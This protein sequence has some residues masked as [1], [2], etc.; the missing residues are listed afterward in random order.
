MNSKPTYKEL[1]EE[2]A[3][4]KISN[5]L[6]KKSPIV[7]FLW[8]N[9]ETWPVEYVSENVKNVFG[10][11]AE[12]FITGKIVYSEIIY[13]EDLQRVENEVNSQSKT[14]FY[15]I[16][17]EPYRIVS[18]A[19]KINWLN[20]ITLIRRNENNEITHFEGIIIDI[21]KQKETEKELIE[22]KLRWKFAVEGNA[23]G[24]WDWNLITNEVF[25]STQWK[26]ML[27]FSENEIQGSL[28]EWGNRVHP[29]DK[30]K[31]YQDINKHIN[32]ET[33][34]YENEHRVLCKDNT[35]KWILDRGKIV[36]YTSDNKPE[37]MIGTHSDITDRKKAEQALKQS[38]ENLKRAQQ[39]AK[40]GHWELDI[41]NNKLFWTDE[42]FRIFDLKPQEFGATYEAFLNNI[43]PDDKEKVDL[44]YANSLKDKIP[45]E[46]EHRLLLR[47]GK[48]KYVV[49]RCNTE[50]NS[51]G[52]PIF[53]IGTILDITERKKSEETLS[54]FKKIRESTSGHMSFIDTNFVYRE[55]NN[56]YIKAHKKKREE[57][58]G[59]TIAE[60]LGKEIFEN[61]IKKEIDACL[62]GEIVKYENW[63]DFAGIGKRYMQVSYYPFY[64]EE[65][66]ISG[67]IVDSYDITDR[68][69]A[70]T[71][72]ANK[73]MLLDN[74]TNRA[75]NV[76]IITTDLDLKIT[77]YN[78]FAE[79]FFG[80]S[81]EQVIGKTVHEMHFME[82]IEPERL[83][84]AFKIVNKTGE[85]NYI[86]NQQ[87]P[88]GKRV[89]S[90]R[91]TK[92]LNPDGELT[93][94]SLFTHD[95]TKQVLA[96]EKLLQR[97][98]YLVALNKTTKILSAGDP[99]TQIQKFIETIGE[100]AHASRTY[101][102]KNHT[103]E[104]NEL[105]LSQI[106]EYVAEGIKPEIDNP[107]LQNL[108]YN[109]WLPR[110]HKTL[111]KGEIV[112]GKVAKFAESEREILE[113]QNI[114]AILVI[115]IIIEKEFWGF[116][117]FDNC[118]ND[119]EL[120][121]AEI[122][123]LKAS[124]EK[125]STKIKERRKQ[126]LLENE[127]KRFH[128]TMNSIDAPVYV[129]DMQTHELLFQNKNTKKLFGNKLGQKCY[130]ALQGLDKP[131]DFCTN[132]K[133][134]DK[135]G[136]PNK[137]Y[138]WE[139]QNTITEQWYQCRDQAIQWTDGRLVRL[140]IATDITERKKIED[141]LKESEEK[142]LTVANFAYDWEYWISPQNEFIYISPSCKRITGYSQDEFKQN[143]E[144]ISSIVHPDDVDNWENH[145]HNDFDKNEIG[146]IEFRIITKSGKQRWI[147]H[148]CQ[149]VFD[150]NGVNI[151]IRG[152]NRDITDKK[153]T[154]QAL[155]VSE[156]RLSK[157]LI[158][159][160]DGMWDWDLITNKVYFD[161]RYYE[162]AGYAVDEFPHEF[163]EFQKRIHSD[164]V[165]NVMLQ[166]QQHLKGEIPRFNV[167]FR[168][169]KKSGDW[170]WI[171]GRGQIVERDKNNKPL[172]F[173][174]THT[175]ITE[176]K[177][178][179][180][181]LK[182]SEEK[183][184]LLFEKNSD[185]LTL[186]ELSPDGPGKFIA[187][188]DAA[189]INSGY[190]REE[191]HEMTAI[192]INSP[193]S[194]KTTQTLLPV[195]FEKKII[196][197]RGS[198]ISK[199]GKT[200]A[201]ENIIHLFKM[202]E[203]EM[204]LTVSRDI[205]DLLKHEQ[206]IIDNSNEL[207]ILN[208]KIKKNEQ[209]LKTII[210]NQGEGFCI[211]NFDKEFIFSNPAACKIFGIPNGQLCGRKLQEFIEENEWDRVLQQTAK[212]KS[213][214]TSTYE[215]IISL[216]DRNKKNLMITASP[217]YDTNNNI[218]GT[219]GIFR[220]IT[221]IKK[222]AQALKENEEKLQSI[223]KS[224]VDIVFMLDKENRFVS[225][226]ATSSDLYLES[227]IF[228]GKKHSEIMPKQIDDLFNK[229]MINVKKG[230]TEEYEYS[231]EK[232]DKIHWYALKLSPILNEGK[233]DGTVSVIRDITDRKNAELDLKESEVKL[234]ESNITK[235]KFF[236]II[237]HDLKSP[238]NSML[239]FSEILNE[240]FDEY[241]TEKKKRFIWI[242]NEGLQNTLKL[243]EN[244][245]QWSQSQKGIIAFNPE[246]INLHIKTKE[247]CD[248]LKQS[249]ENKSIELI[250]QLDLNIYVEADKD[251]LATIIRNLLSNAIKY[252]HKHG[253][254][255]IKTFS[256]PDENNIQYLGISVSDNGVGIP[257]EIQSKLFEI[258][259]NT[260]MKGTDNEKG[261]GLGLIL[262][263]EFVEKHGGKIW[264]ESEVGKGSSLFFTIPNGK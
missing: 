107:D 90:S 114:K 186:A 115:P 64:N 202:N 104:K 24:L 257:K 226:N 57:V 32:G 20:D 1:E 242:I 78:P 40:I 76:S 82:N 125:I 51:K 167:E 234:R 25:F 253:E 100:A 39:I 158:A 251:M 87:L 69:Q 43:H 62:S 258:G 264:I 175:D 67:V 211:M 235:D 72:L 11:T 248:L 91:V 71:K 127:N 102:F 142:F 131:C 215:L 217:D 92:M 223:L 214:E 88:S 170:L 245:L 162:M 184:K 256:V 129:A 98:N 227:E 183:F 56:A 261:T 109:D 249:S 243:L 220:D 206:F 77:T 13:P 225:A 163:E 212:R 140:E 105:L 138:V 121:T 199:T 81:A 173:I 252:T 151:G 99:K 50:Y 174:G 190:S 33:D 221:D 250:N 213:N 86:V 146:I 41:V 123:Y 38:D 145:K 144:L 182:E 60:L 17:H 74:I 22:S 8:K 48:I 154:E 23:D 260:S 141:A 134:L 246:K 152:S 218:T 12:D 239:G 192:D 59:H 61:V 177:K 42:V 216:P 224:M 238:F 94:Y 189:C 9:Q 195:L 207:Q 119:I 16:E 113:P 31:V 222:T 233:F 89:L 169:K 203:R 149:T 196:K 46:I 75:S 210:E 263:K 112:S 136:N 80:Y 165:E 85:Y 236:S 180:Q 122:E 58:I 156:D 84:K 157:T 47:T 240:K 259:E 153:N 197:Y 185:A 201:V 79:K 209:R 230:K 255:T 200:T 172:R 208:K 191:L 130:I 29:D 160:N 188:N 2:L 18:K 247:I 101:I 63:F 181:A 204:I 168:F 95:V 15:S 159:A 117:G 128:A 262:C 44:A 35:Y 219:I 96:E 19:G 14:G 137:P 166:A 55:V 6:I 139:F 148:V 126:E 193:E 34:F 37:R 28:Q 231:L 241:S 171:M 176:R 54:L 205:A 237:A 108:S 135:N 83:T 132:N 228:L 229:A 7:K 97:E 36:S 26:K 21:T 4:L 116:I 110:W 194:L 49:E 5:N 93:G 254:I 198:I 10:Y 106:A 66:K 111:K 3:F 232:L 52:D 73:T 161:P 178:T 147:G 30:E 124:A 68:K 133:L 65:N 150:K 187:V 27:G 143:P 164:D 53:S 70:E 120:Q 103:N 155:K 118:I 244:L 179:E 45:Y